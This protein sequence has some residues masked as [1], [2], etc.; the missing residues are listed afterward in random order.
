M[1]RFE[2]FV[3]STSVDLV[4]FRQ[5][6]IDQ[7]LRMGQM[8]IGMEHFGSRTQDATTVSL[9]EVAG[10]DLFI[11]IYA[12][13]YGYTPEEDGLSITEQE[14]HEA[15][16]RGKRCLCYFADES[17]RPASAT[18]PDWKLERLAE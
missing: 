18:E 4:D 9:A 17:L 8:P 7:L 6:V 3:S 1:E 16:S 14:Y 13:R 5:V 12:F 15:R 10:C 11:G 2:V